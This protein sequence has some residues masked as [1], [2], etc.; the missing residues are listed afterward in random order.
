MSGINDE[1]FVLLTS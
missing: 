1:D